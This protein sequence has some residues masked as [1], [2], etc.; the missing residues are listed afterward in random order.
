MNLEQMYEHLERRA[1]SCLRNVNPDYGS[2]HD[3]RNILYQTDKA[4]RAMNQAC[5]A[6]EKAD[7]RLREIADSQ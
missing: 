5:I 1:L 2:I 6:I 3:Y 4:M 7:A